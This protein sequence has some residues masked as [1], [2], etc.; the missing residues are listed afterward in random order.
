MFHKDGST[1]MSDKRKIVVELITDLNVGGA[2]KMLCN[3]LRHIDRAQFN[4]VVI[5]LLNGDLKKEI[6]SLGIPVYTF[7]LK[8]GIVDIF[9]VINLILRIRKL[10]PHLIHG[11]MYHSHVIALIARVFTKRYVPCIWSIHNSIYSL[12]NEKKMTGFIIKLGGYLSAY[13]ELIHYVSN[14]SM[15]QHV[16]I[17]YN[18]SKTV[19]IPNAF[20]TDIFTYRSQKSDQLRHEL[21]IKSEEV[22]V[23]LI[24]RYHPVKDHGNF[25]EAASLLLKKRDNV[26]FILAGKGINI[27]NEFLRKKIEQLYLANR[28]HLLGERE[29]IPNITSSLDIACSAS[30]SEAF[31]MTV[32]EAM[33]CGIPCVVTDVGDSKLV[34]GDT[35]KAVPPR[36]PKAFADALMELID[37]GNE[38]RMRLGVKARN[39]IIEN[40]TIRTITNTYENIY[41]HTI[42]AHAR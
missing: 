31:P 20:D 24:G 38:G 2:E 39:R 6:E 13:P 5:A 23:G 19:I 40:Y 41:H 22:L 27:E 36:N 37:L 30:Y 25:L 28:V 4:P 35:G 10:N 8:K 15:Q 1:A 12:K 32:G 33:S 9:S 42:S 18:D 17:G 14:T 34:V 26:H 21:G 16:K 11:W 29:D 7:S 3:F